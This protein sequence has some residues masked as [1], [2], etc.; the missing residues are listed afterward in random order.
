MTTPSPAP[1]TTSVPP[2]GTSTSPPASP[3]PAGP[4]IPSSLPALGVGTLVTDC[5]LESVTDP[6][7]GATTLDVDP[8]S[9]EHIVAGPGTL[10]G[11][12]VSVDKDGTPSV[13]WLPEASPYG[14]PL[15]ALINPA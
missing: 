8:A 13:V 7:T 11:V 2:P 6:R 4:L 12:I 3:A 14:L 10:V 9:G 5:D 15:L 1:T